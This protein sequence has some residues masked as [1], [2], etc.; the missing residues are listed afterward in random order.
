MDVADNPAGALVTDPGCLREVNAITPTL[1]RCL[2][3]DDAGLRT[4]EALIAEQ[5][6]W[7]VLMLGVTRKTQSDHRVELVAT[8]RN[9][10]RV[11]RAG[12]LG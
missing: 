2:T 10:R 5:R 8:D 1:P 12:G 4:L 6:P 3:V 9:L 7:A 11:A